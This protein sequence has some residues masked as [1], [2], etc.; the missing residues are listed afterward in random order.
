M[1]NIKKR[2]T[3]AGLKINGADLHA[4]IKVIEKIW[5]RTYPD[6]VFEYQFL[7]EK[8]TGFYKE[9]DRLSQ[10]YKIFA[11]IAFLIST[12]IA[13]YFVHQ[14]LMQYV[15][16][17]SISGWIFVAGGLLALLIALATVSF[18]AFRAAAVNPVKNLRSE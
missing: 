3:S 12:P 15:Y 16:R 10:I 11:S 7:D 4:T 5:N 14:W 13:W 2:F 1:V 8:I 17:I 6:Y 9:E 18:Q